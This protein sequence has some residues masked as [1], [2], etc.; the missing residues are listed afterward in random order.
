VDAMPRHP[1]FVD[2]PQWVLTSTC[3]AWLVADR[4]NLQALRP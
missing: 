4:H 1:P 3:W 2:P